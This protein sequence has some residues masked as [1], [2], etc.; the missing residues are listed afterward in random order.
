MKSLSKVKDLERFIEKHGED[1]FIA[2][3]ISKMAAYKVQKFEQKIEQLSQDLKKFEGIY[4][5]ESHAFFEEFGKGLLGDEMDFIEWSSLF[6]MR[7]RLLEKKKE[8]EGMI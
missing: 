7:S 4:G 1:D 5:K 8:L 3:T 6:Q 2:R